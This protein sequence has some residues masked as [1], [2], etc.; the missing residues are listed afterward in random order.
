VTHCQRILAI[1]DD[2]DWHEKSEFY[3]F[4]V[5]HSRISELRNKHG[6]T[7]EKEH[8]GGKVFYRLVAGPLNE[9]EV[10]PHAGP[11]RTACGESGPMAAAT[12]GKKEAS[13]SL[14]GKQLSVFEAAA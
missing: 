12:D 4:C 6:Y 8:R 3:G 14:S 10:S 5:L 13:A 1:L 7:I 11:I 9:V 2:G